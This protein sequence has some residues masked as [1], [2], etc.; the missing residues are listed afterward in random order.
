M[1]K[2][3]IYSSLSGPMGEKSRQLALDRFDVRKV[4]AQILAAMAD[5]DHRIVSSGTAIR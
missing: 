4:N 2:L 5:F 3:L 1:E